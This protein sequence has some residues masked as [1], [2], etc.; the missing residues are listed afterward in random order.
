MKAPY[1]FAD[2]DYSAAESL[3]KSFDK[4]LLSV[5]EGLRANGD[6]LIPFVVSGEF[7]E[8]SNHEW[9]QLAKRLFSFSQNSTISTKR[10]EKY[11]EAKDPA[12]RRR[13]HP[14]FP[15]L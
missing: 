2:I 15:V 5:V 8:R 3:N 9:N 12:L 4:I 13:C 7:V 11:D 6:G 10:G 14:P 1:L